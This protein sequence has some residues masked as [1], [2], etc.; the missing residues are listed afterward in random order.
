MA[1]WSGKIAFQ[2]TKETDLGVWEE[3]MVERPYYG[4]VIKNHRMLEN[5][6]EINDGINTSNQISFVADPYAAENFHN[7]RYTYFMGTR[8]RVVNVDVQ[9]PRLIMTLGGVWNGQEGG[10]SCCSC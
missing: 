7:I 3:T 4:D 2:T 8:W 10:T 5:S 9:Y 6:S 1:K